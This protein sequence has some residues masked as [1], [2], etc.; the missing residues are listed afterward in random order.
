MTDVFLE[1]LKADWRRQTVDLD[2][3]RQRLIWRRW[4]TAFFIGAE[5]LGVGLAVGFAIWLLANVPSLGLAVSW[6]LR[7]CLQAR[8]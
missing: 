3:V 4:R 6:L 2:Q 1:G 7:R 5:V 8:F